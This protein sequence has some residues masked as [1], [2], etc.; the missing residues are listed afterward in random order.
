MFRIK[1]KSISARVSTSRTGVRSRRLPSIVLSSG[2]VIKIHP[3]RHVFITENDL[4]E[5]YSRLLL[6]ADQIVVSLN[7]PPFSE[8]NLSELFKSDQ[9][10]V[11]VV[12]I[13]T[14]ADVVEELE[15]ES[16]ILIEEPVIE[17]EPVIVETEPVIEDA[18]STVEIASEPEVPVSKK[19][20]RKRRTKSEISADKAKK[21]K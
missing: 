1:G 15:P 2:A 12:S 4:K 6:I 21:S 20:R 10:A 5:N 16:V 13:D 8:L 9:E 18:P 11:P 19:S 3:N 14:A 7:S 17:A